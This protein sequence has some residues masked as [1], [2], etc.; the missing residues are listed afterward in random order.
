M[1]RRTAGLLL[2]IA[3]IL[4]CLVP[5]SLIE[6]ENLTGQQ[7]LEAHLAQ[8]AE[9]D[10]VERA[11]VRAAAEQFNDAFEQTG[12]A[13]R[14]PFEEDLD[15]ADSQF[16]V[17][18]E[19]FAYMVIPSIDVSL[20]VYLGASKKHLGVGLAQVEG[21]S[22][23][24]GG[25]GTRSVIAGHRGGYYNHYLLFADQLAA[26]D[27]IYVIV[28]GELLVYEVYGSEVIHPSE[29]EKLAAVEGQDTL[30]LLTC[31]P[32]PVNSHRLL[33]DARRVVP[34][35]EEASVDKPLEQLR[36]DLRQAELAPVASG[37]RMWMWVSRAAIVVLA[38]GLVWTTVL[39]LRG[40]RHHGERQ[41]GELHPAPQD[42]Q[43]D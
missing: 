14:D 8:L 20:P 25:D 40:W 31:T 24:V 18:G 42:D 29:W 6:Y 34:P 35:T 33:V 26:G 3:G 32:P 37:A 1:L 38:V 5:L 28:Q 19:Q 12:Q 22:L 43:R 2:V 21:T 41:T 13:A 23:P 30:T 27:R 39:L 4:F 16:A 7:R 9:R 36:E 17:T 11:Q 10:P 15:V